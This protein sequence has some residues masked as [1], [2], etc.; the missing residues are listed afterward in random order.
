MGV[1]SPILL[2]IILF[3]HF[4]LLAM[5]L[6]F[7]QEHHSNRPCINF[8]SVQQIDIV[9]TSDFP[10]GIHLRACGWE[11]YDRQIFNSG[12]YEAAVYKDFNRRIRRATERAQYLGLVPIPV[13]LSVIQNIRDSLSIRKSRIYVPLSL[14]KE[15]DQ[16][17]SILL[18]YWIAA[19]Q[20]HGSVMGQVSN[21]E[22]QNI[23]SVLRT[24][25]L[26]GEQLA[27]NNVLLMRQLKLSKNEFESPSAEPSS[28]AIPLRIDLR[29]SVKL[30]ALQGTRAIVHS[31]LSN[32]SLPSFIEMP[33]FR[34][35]PLATQRGELRFATADKIPS[36]LYVIITCEDVTWKEVSQL[37]KATERLLLVQTCGKKTEIDVAELRPHFRSQSQS[38][39]YISLFLPLL[40]K[41]ISNHGLVF[42]SL[43]GNPQIIKPDSNDTNVSLTQQ[44][45]STK[46]DQQLL[47]SILSLQL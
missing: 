45:N 23:A 46:V 9:S 20:N 11:V 37:R 30:T 6:L 3:T 36:F 24:E 8:P 28:F 2:K 13:S 43:R 31:R 5:L 22:A 26:V 34:T 15:G 39:K 35:H 17:E 1:K 38:L 27:K 32:Y 47:A 19:A 44:Q 41:N 21:D 42:T 4:T 10:E 40:P 14:W 7:S 16:L 33:T 29:T 18:T 25:K 12:T